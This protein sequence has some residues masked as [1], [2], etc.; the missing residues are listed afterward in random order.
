MDEN[1]PTRDSNTKKVY[2]NRTMDFIKRAYRE[3]SEVNHDILKNERNIYIHNFGSNNQITGLTLLNTVIWACKNW[4]KTITQ[5]SWRSYRA[6]LIFLSE[7]YLQ[8]ELIDQATYDKIENALLKTKGLNKKDVE[9]KTSA[10]KQKHLSIPDLKKIDKE[11][12]R[13][14]SQW[15]KPTRIWLRVGILTGLRPVEWRKAKLLETDNT[16]TLLVHNAK[17]TNNRANGE[18]RTLHLNHLSKDDI[19]LIKTHLMIVDKFNSKKTDWESLYQ[20]C[21]NLL[22]TKNKIVFPNRK[23]NPTLYSARHQYSANIKATGCKPEEV[24][25]LMGH[26]SDLTAQMTYGK[27]IN[28]TRGRKPDIEKKEIDSVRVH[29]KTEQYF[30]FKK[31]EKNKQK[32]NNK[33][34]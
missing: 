24:A 12:S 9:P 5:E 28:G 27:K 33:N 7:L 17:N 2:L 30:S 25:A 6:P 11:L 34:K 16:A 15:G 19:N 4:S 1:K 22:R 8:S 14:K 13:S 23:K 3:A 10:K 32:G 29:K 31:L 26:A 21:S 18:T 20:G